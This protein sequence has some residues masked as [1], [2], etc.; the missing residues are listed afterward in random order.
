MDGSGGPWFRGNLVVA[1]DTIVEVG[2]AEPEAL[3]VIEAEGLVAAPGFLDMHAHSEYGLIVDPRA[4]SKV[5]QGVTTEVL[6]EHLS[7]GPVLGLAVDDPM[8]VA[9]P[10]ERDW[11]TLGGY[12]DRLEFA[13]VGPNVV[14]YVGAGQVRA[15]VMGYEE[16]AASEAELQAMET[17]VSQAMEEGAFALS[18]GMAYIPNAFASTEELIRLARVAA[19]SGGFYVSHLRG[20][21]AGLS[22]GIRIA[23]EA[24]IALEIHHLNSTSG[25]RIAEYAAVIAEARASGVDVT[26]NVYPYIAGWTYLRSLLPRWAQEGGVGR[27]LRRLTDP[28]ERQLLLSE[29]RAGERERPRWERTFVSSFREEVDGLSILDLGEARGLSPAEAL[30]DLLVEQEGEGFQISFGNTE[31]NL[32]QALSLPFTHIGSDGSA[33]ARGMRTPMGKPHPRSFGTHPR[34]FARYVREE[35]LLSLEEA[36]RKMTSAPANRLGLTDR[37][38][39]RPGMRAD[40]VLFDPAT[41]RD[42]A[43]FE[44][45]ER[46]PEGIEW[47]FVNGIAVVA[48]GEPTGALPGRVLRGPGYREK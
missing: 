26:G 12:L 38:L 30:L 31:A 37:G 25:E 40:L 21:L 32:R 48:D 47:V 7:G 13:G 42:A 2:S 17:L 4:L 18:S 43:T 11:T 16:R 24:G 14:S 45:P 22:E 36:V 28:G 23:R 9:P 1:G 33:L 34:V 10:I 5:A 41:V 39:L 3:R 29:L 8:M 20:G 44:E 27:M 6:G 19:S 15:S 35:G 46:Y